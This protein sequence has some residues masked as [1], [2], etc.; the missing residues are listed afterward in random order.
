MQAGARAQLQRGM[1]LTLRLT[2]GRSV[3]L[4]SPDGVVTPEGDYYYQQLNIPVP[5]IY[6]YEQ[7]LINGKYVIG[8]D[9]KKH[10]VRTMKTGAWEVTHR[11]GLLQA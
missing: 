8:Y 3:R 9:G 11:C 6:T 7:P 1:A 5:T 4:V 2:T 10:D